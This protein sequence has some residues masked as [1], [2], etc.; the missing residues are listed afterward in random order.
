MTFTAIVRIPQLST[1]AE[2]FIWQF[3]FF[4]NLAGT[5][6]DG[7]WIEYSDDLNSGKF[8]C[9]TSA[10]STAATPVDSGVTVAIDTWYYIEINVNAAAN[11]VKF[12]IDGSLKATMTSNIP[13]GTG[14][15]T[16]FG[17]NLRK[18][19]GVNNRTALIDYVGLVLETAR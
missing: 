8:R 2:R 12:Y 13:S 4:D 5:Q 15:T 6:I 18:T 9:C 3:G 7:A 1:S 16:G 17:V 11:S 19:L 10:A 14:Q